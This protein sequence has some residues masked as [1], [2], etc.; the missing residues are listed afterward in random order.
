MSTTAVVVRHNAYV[1]SITLLQVSADVLALGG[2]SNA[3][4]VM[5]TDLNRDVLSQSGLLVDVAV[6]AGPNDL[7][8]A[9]EAETSDAA[10]AALQAADAMLVR[11]RGATAPS[12][13]QEVG[14][15]RSIRSAHR[16]LAHAN[17]AVISVPGGYAASEA[18]QALANGL[19]VFLFSDNVP[20]ADEVRLKRDATERDL[21]V[22]G[23]DCGTAIIDGVGLGFSN[24]VRRGSVG[25]I[26]ASGT[27]L[28]EVSSLLHTAGA[29]ISHAIGTGGRDLST[30]VGGLTTLR[31]LELLKNDRQTETIVLI[32]KPPALEVA[33]RVLQAATATGKTIIACL[34]GSAVI[35][36]PGVEVARN[37]YHAARLAAG[38]HGAWG[39]VTAND[40]PRTRFLADQ[41]AV[42]GLFCGGTLRDEA[43]LALGD[44]VEHELI[45]F[46]DDQYTRGRAHPMIDPTLRNAAIV[47]SGADPRVAVVLLDVI[48]GRGSHPDPAGA[49]VPAIREALAAAG[50]E[51]R[52]LAV[53]AHV[54]GTNADPQGLERQEDTLRAA[55]VHVLGSNYHAAV[56]AS[57]LLEAVSVA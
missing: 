36:P 40:L 52:E 1:D 30:D 11:R 53:L 57:R 55:G 16:S 7:V 44:S 26:A 13:D 9:V 25:I 28:Q 2:V 6:A 49:T 23:P 5:A 45:D 8:I 14:P 33:D 37:L 31:A 56:A 4:L 24:A 41:H 46:G 20:V 42:R 29:G 18:Q 27:G 22:M 39:G 21:L 10:G 48:I 35:A 38:T 34:L 3:A 50:R 19:H 54:V 43:E 47:G 12:D 32:S 15:P 17:L 51:G